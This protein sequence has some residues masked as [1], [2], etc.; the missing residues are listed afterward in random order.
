MIVKLTSIPDD[1][2]QDDSAA[3]S[4][5]NSHADQG[6]VLEPANTGSAAAGID[7]RSSP[8]IASA[9]QNI[10]I[11]TLPDGGVDT[12]RSF[13][14]ELI[15]RHQLDD[16]FYAVDLGRLCL[17]YQAFVTA[18]PRIRPFYAVKCNPEPVML[19]VLAALGCGFD[20]A[21]AAEV[22]AVLAAGA[23]PGDIVLAQACKRPVDV[24]VAVACGVQLM[25]FDCEDELEKVAA[26]CP[27]AH[28]VLRIRADDPTADVP[29]GNK[30]GADATA[31]APAMLAAAQRL[32]LRVAGVAFHVGSGSKNPE[33][34]ARG[35]RLARWVFDRATA[36]GMQP[37][38]LDIGGGFWAHFGVTGGVSMG[39]VAEV[40]NAA[41]EAQFPKAE[42]AGL[43]VIAEP[44][45]YFGEGCST[46]FTLVHTVKSCPR[47]ERRYYITDGLYGSFAAV[48]SGRLGVR[49]HVLRSP[50]LGPAAAAEV[51]ARV[52]ST[53]FGPTCDGWDRIMHDVPM[54]LLRR[55]DWLQFAEHGAYRAALASEFNGIAAAASE[56]FYV[57][58]DRP[59]RPGAPGDVVLQ[60]GQRSAQHSMG[61]LEGALCLVATPQ[62][63]G[64]AAL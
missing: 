58:S 6:P 16:N 15:G 31:E 60:K 43:Q 53:V 62:D 55:G 56:T 1:L 45:R 51:A 9:L 34:Y 3:L 10:P 28:V 63:L 5:S 33:A 11:V 22:Q 21:S 32:G 14:A 57:W 36:L 54:P 44:G 2:Q 24:R 41:L 19:R 64:L 50:A 61:E 35:I 52:P 8:K 47:G 20:C 13:G 48:G 59:V 17:L 4:D 30:F 27:S 49:A 38:V 26:A 42:W 23:E 7:L 25:T 29:L 39:G 40:V 18:M 37:W 46:L 12:L